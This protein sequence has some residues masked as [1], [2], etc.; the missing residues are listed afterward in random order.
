MPKCGLDHLLVARAKSAGSFRD[1]PVED[2]FVQSLRACGPQAP[3][4]RLV[5]LKYWSSGDTKES[6]LFY[7][8]MRPVA[9]RTSLTPEIFLEWVQVFRGQRQ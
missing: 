2:G 6:A 5:R 8:G 7:S 3:Q 4:V 1:P 9:P